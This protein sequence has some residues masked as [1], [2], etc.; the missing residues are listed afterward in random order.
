VD[1]KR[2]GLVVLGALVV[3]GLV[4]GVAFFGPW[5]SDGDATPSVQPGIDVGDPAT[6]AADDFASA[7][8]AGTLAEIAYTPE[9]GD[10]A[11]ITAFLVGGLTS[12]GGA[13][14]AV[15]VTSV[16][17]ADGSGSRAVATAT[18]TWTLDGGRPWSYD[19]SFGLVR[20]DEAWQVAWTPSVIEPTLRAG[21]ALRVGRVAATRGTIVDATGKVLVAEKGAVTV[22]IRRSRAPDP[23]G[24]ARTVARLTG[25][26]P[27]PLVAAVLDAGPEDFVVVTTLARADYEKIRAQIQPLPG[28]VFREEQ[29]ESGL[30][31]NYARALLGT[32]GLATPEIIAASGGRVVAG[33]VAGLT[34][35][36]AGQ[37]EVLAGSPGVSVQA[38]SASPG[39]VPR[40][41][42]V[43]PPVDGTPVTVTIDQRIQ[44]AADAAVA[45]TA[46]PSALVAIRVSTGDV[47]AVANGPV[48]QSAFNRAMVGRYPP[49]STFK[50]A[51]TLALLQKG[52]TPDTVVDCP[53][54][55]TVGKVF[56]NAEG[57][58]LGPVPFRKVFAD[59]C[60]TAFIGQAS[61]ISTEELGLYAAT[62]GYRDLDVGAPVFGGSVPVAVDSTEHAAQV[63]GQGRV[64]ASPFAVALASASVAN[65]TSLVPRLV[66]DASA[67]DPGPGAPLPPQRVTQL[68][69]LMREVVVDGTGGAVKAVPGGDV[70]A[71]TGTAEFGTE[72]PPR[73]HAW[74][75][76]YQGD[77]A[78]AVLVEDGG[79]GGAV[80]APLA[81][82][83]L[84]TVANG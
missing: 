79:F 70:F 25:V 45:G 22:G 81:A 63:I 77:L 32:T 21:E 46:N 48:D 50:V 35:L 28:T 8:E 10:V 3:L 36:E 73:T 76:G 39:A 31:D 67:P 72:V 66:V 62:L 18:I 59:S 26:A 57:E 19:T 9:S 83:F 56:R 71:K 68:R 5:G 1:K 42:K 40:A 6:K 11:T 80:A 52:L 49:G 43:Y 58:A 47:L 75:T 53:A 30:P 54:T 78:F 65:G 74:F 82:A 38:V 23:E 34:G 29:A 7:W 20:V 17:A 15:E 41:L 55:I 12:A 2:V 27:E 16:R 69:D 61:T 37:D 84:T 51:T 14:P 64:E 44:A 33:D 13:R 4:A 60:N 24:T